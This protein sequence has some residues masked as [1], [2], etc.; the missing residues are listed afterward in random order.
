MRVLVT[1][2]T[3]FVGS[4]ISARLLAEGHEVWVTGAE[5][6]AGL[7]GGARLV[8]WGEASRGR[9][10]VCF[11]QA[12]N[13]DTL[14]GDAERMNAANV[15]GP[16]ALFYSLLRGGC[17]RFVYASSTAVYGNR[18]APYTEETPPNPL[19]VY[20]RS[21]LAFDEF[22]AGFAE[23]TGAAVFGLRYC[24]VYGP[25][26]SHKGR[27]ASM[28]FHLSVQVLSGRRPR[29]FRDGEQRRDWV[30]VSDV[31]EANLACLSAGSGGVFNVA[32]G[33][34]VSFNRLVGLV[35]AAAGTGLEPEYI[36]CGF[37][38]SFQTNTEC[39][40]SRAREQIGWSPRYDIERG[41]G[42]YLPL[43]RA[44]L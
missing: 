15:F 41:V 27:R 16:A 36:E 12:A 10:D 8:P 9:F 26:E 37:G 2:G 11:H 25:G 7:C 40:V 19:N 20:A 38:A 4:N 24:N 22:A 18:P 28:V 5:G 33:E 31:V 32:G 34:G 13:N 14:D 3:G 29:I 30:H 23:E 39:D 6:E 21:K 42:E 43:L 17:G 1:G 44:S 35:N